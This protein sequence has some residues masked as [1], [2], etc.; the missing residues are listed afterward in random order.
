MRRKLSEEEPRSVADKTT[1]RWRTNRQSKHDESDNNAKPIV[2]GRRSRSN[3]PRI[4]KSPKEEKKKTLKRK[5]EEESKDEDKSEEVDS[6]AVTPSVKKRKLTDTG[7]AKPKPKPKPKL[8]TNPKPKRI[9]K[10]LVKNDNQNTKTAAPSSGETSIAAPS[11]GETN[12]TVTSSGETST[13]QAPP[14]GESGTTIVTSSGETNQTATSSGESSKTLVTSSGETNA[15]ATSSGETK[16]SKPKSKPKKRASKKTSKTS[17]TSNTSNTADHEKP[18][19]KPRKQKKNDLTKKTELSTEN[20]TSNGQNSDDKKP[21]NNSEK[22]IKCEQKK[23]VKSDSEKRSLICEKCGFI[24]TTRTLL[25]KHDDR[26]HKEGN[27]EYIRDNPF[28]CTVCD[29]RAK[30]LGVIKGHLKKHGLRM[31][32]YC[33]FTAEQNQVEIHERN[34]HSDRVT[35]KLCKTCQRYI[36]CDSDDFETHFENCDGK[37][38]P[39]VCKTCGKEYEY[40]S[41]LKMHSFTHDSGPKKYHCEKC[42]YKTHYK[43]NLQKHMAN[44][45]AENREKNIPCPECEKKFFNEDNLRRHLVSHSEDR[46]YSCEE[47]SKSFKTGV[48]LKGH[49]ET[50]ITDRPYACG[51]DSCGKSFKSTKLLRLHQDDIHKLLPRKFKCNF[52]GCDYIFFKSSHLIRHR[53]T[54]TGERKYACDWSNCGKAFRH[55]DNLKVHYRQHTNEKPVKCHLCDFACRQRNSLTWHLKRQHPETSIDGADNGNYSNGSTEVEED[56][57]VQVAPVVVAAAVV[58]KKRIY[59]RRKKVEKVEE[60]EEKKSETG[61]KIGELGL[62][63]ILSNLELLN[64]E[65]FADCEDSEIEEIVN[66]TDPTAA[67]ARRRKRKTD[68]SKKQ[69]RV[70]QKRA[71]KSIKPK[72]VETETAAVSATAPDVE[73]GETAA[74]PVVESETA[75]ETAADPA[76]EPSTETAASAAEPDTEPSVEPSQP[77]VELVNE[78]I[79]EPSTQISEN[80]DTEEEEGDRKQ[81]RRILSPRTRKTAAAGAGAGAAGAGPRNWLINSKSIESQISETDIYNF[82]SDDEQTSVNP[83]P[84]GGATCVSNNDDS[85][86]NDHQV[87][88]SPSVDSKSVIDKMKERYITDE[89]SPVVALSPLDIAKIEI[90]HN[91]HIPDNTAAPA[92]AAAAA[93]EQLTDGQQTTSAPA[94]EQTICAEQIASAHLE[95]PASVPAELIASAPEV[96]QTASVEQTVPAESTEMAPDSIEQMVSVSTEQTA[97]ASTEQMVPESTEQMVSVSGDDYMTSSGDTVPPGGELGVYTAAAADDDDDEMINSIHPSQQLF[98]NEE[99]ENDEDVN[100]IN[101]ARCEGEII[102]RQLLQKYLEDATMDEFEKEQLIK[103]TEPKTEPSGSTTSTAEH[104]WKPD[105]QPDPKSISTSTSSTAAWSTVDHDKLLT[106]SVE[107]LYDNSSL[108]QPSGGERIDGATMY[109]PDLNGFY[110]T[111][112]AS[113]LIHPPLYPASGY[114]TPVVNKDTCS[115]RGDPLIYSQSATPYLPLATSM[116]QSAPAYLD[117]YNAAPHRQQYDN[118]LGSLAMS[119]A[120]YI[121]SEVSKTV[122]R[123]VYSQQGWAL[124]ETQSLRLTHSL[125]PPGSHQNWESS[126]RSAAAAAAS[127]PYIDTSSR[128]SA[129]LPGQPPPDTLDKQTFDRYDHMAYLNCRHPAIGQHPGF[130]QLPPPLGGASKALSDQYR[131]DYHRSFS[132]QATTDLYSTMDKYFYPRDSMYSPHQRIHQPVGLQPDHHHHHHP[133]SPAGA[134]PAPAPQHNYVPREYP[135]SRYPQ[136]NPY[137]FIPDPKQYPDTGKY[138][139]GAPMQFIPRAGSTTTH[140]PYRSTMPLYNMMNHRGYM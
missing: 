66:L 24:T 95:Q 51:I 96:E 35:S 10:K 129:Y 47:C 107:R 40:A 36:K 83:P 28:K 103:D 60:L 19:K 33:E 137:D 131:S 90:K 46:P 34:I 7:Q 123:R 11:S 31:C 72:P 25:K 64:E 92:A 4:R 118:P 109:R 140:D 68:G 127:Y 89:K 70:Y 44:K 87:E 139:Q 80:D 112:G 84:I 104:Q 65:S 63:K 41:A 102:D 18:V 21:E 99:K 69:Q 2:T 16:E 26:C 114:S 119:T 76:A 57:S 56:A 128:S 78:P 71:S 91:I 53:A 86:R 3:S 85:T 8:K 42:H 6:T 50:H 30:K 27:E 108:L 106:H 23:R 48:A 17:N 124:Q 43:I 93:A 111:R 29:Y 122:E 45:H 22:P 14:S 61:E 62:L 75:T 116:N 54:H 79:L 98:D 110:D 130:N 100:D 97:P 88:E 82:T 5:K 117:P 136:T 55:A 101:I 74:E 32:H 59:K 67:A 126:S 125:F 13:E 1:N 134:P 132:T 120:K 113:G 105:P 138:S 15:A 39:F 52:D 81:I 115:P 58:K 73:L 133:F 49:L 9:S 121:E 38:R 37:K 20:G 77:T 94:V 12:Q 135:T